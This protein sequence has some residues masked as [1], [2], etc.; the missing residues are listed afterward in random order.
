VGGSAAA[1]IQGSR[2]EIYARLDSHNLTTTHS[3]LWGG[4]S[5]QTFKNQQS[6]SHFPSISVCGAKLI[7]RIMGTRWT[8]SRSLLLPQLVGVARRHVFPKNGSSRKSLG[9][10]KFESSFPSMFSLQ[11]CRTAC[12][13]SVENNCDIIVS[14]AAACTCCCHHTCEVQYWPNGA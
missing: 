11:R 9:R 5:V 3:L 10:A 6:I 8:R 7:D 1:I 14:F 12:C 13:V 4:I 2:V